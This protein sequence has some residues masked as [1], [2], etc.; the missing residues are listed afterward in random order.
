M[1]LNRFYFTNPCMCGRFESCPDDIPDS[2]PERTYSDMVTLLDEPMS[3][4]GYSHEPD[5]DTTS[6]T[7]ERSDDTF[8]MAKGNLTLLEKA[9][10][11]ESQR[12]M[13]MKDRA[14]PERRHKIHSDASRRSYFI[15]GDRSGVRWL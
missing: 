1:V 14:A 6:V 9:I 5:E 4:G 10:A 7:S 2:V 13:V 11:L 3:P 8:D 12:N 15:K